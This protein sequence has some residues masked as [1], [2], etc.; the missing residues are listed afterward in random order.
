MRK[1]GRDDLLLLAF[2][3]FVMSEMLGR[4]IRL[5]KIIHGDDY[6]M[7]RVK[8]L[9]LASE[10]RTHIENIAALLLSPAPPELILNRHCV[11]CEFQARCRQKAIEKDG[12]SLLARM[13]EREG[14]QATTR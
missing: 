10:V 14:A 11:Q 1:L 5:G 2:D 9:P 12:L 4:D 8:T 3:A 13:S 6:A 7:R